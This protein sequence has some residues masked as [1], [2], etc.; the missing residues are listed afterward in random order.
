MRTL[1]EDFRY[2]WRLLAKTPGLTAVVVLTLALGIG[3]NA[4]IFSLVNGFLLRP[5]PV[6]HPEEI[7]VLG[8]TVKGDSPFLFTFSYPAFQ[9]YRNQAASSADVFGFMPTLLGLSADG[10][11]DQVLSSYVT[12]NYFSALGI[13]P[14]L[15]RL[16]MPSEE[17]QP[18]RQP[19]LILGYAYWQKRFGGSPNVIGKQVRV[20]GHSATIVG[21]V[22]KQFQG[23]MSL[24]E[25]DLYMPFSNGA[26]LEDAE[27]NPVTDRSARIVRTMARL[28]PGVSFS[29]AQAT[30][31]VITARLAKQYPS[32]DANLT[33]KVYREQ[34]ARPEP[35]ANNIVAVIAGFFLL[36]AA[37]VLLLACMNVANVL[38][39]R[40][41]VRQREIALRA[42]LGARRVRLIRQM[43]TETVVLGL[44]GGVLGLILGEWANP[45]DISKLVS[46]SLPIRMDYSF[47]W[48][49]FAYGFGAAVVT[50]I[51]VGLLPALRASR[52]DLNGILQQGGR[53]D[54]G[55]GRHRIRS[56][57]V[58][59]Q[60]AGSLLLLVIAGLFVR[61]MQHAESMYLGFDPDRL[62]SLTVDP[63][64]IGYDQTRTESFYRQLK[65]RVQA[66]PGV[67]S[68]SMSF[69]LPFS[70]GG[71]EVDAAAVTVEGQPVAPGQQPPQVFF[72]HVGADYFRTMRVPLLQGRA[73]SDQDD[74]KAP[75]VAI[76]NQTM[77]DRFWPHKN[78]LGQRFTL[79]TPAGAAKTAEIVGVAGN[80]KYVFL[81]EDAT[82]FFYV[83]L[84]QNY[85]SMRALL[86]RTSVTPESLLNPLRDAVRRI[87]PDLPVAQLETMKQTLGGGNGLQIFRVGAQMASIIGGI[88]LL[89]AVV[90]LYGIVS[91]TAAQRTREIGIRMAL[92]GTAR[93]VLRLVIQQGLRML[94]GGLAI[95]LVAALAITRVMTRLLVGI[96]PSDPLTY[97]LV[98]LL[99][100]AIALLA[101]WIPA[102]RATRVDP[103]MALR[104]E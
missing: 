57:L 83:P 74:E 4:L 79:K 77:A 34:L 81:A 25:M 94:L 37:L 31:D 55:S 61:S 51:L 75:V 65:A 86:V 53:S 42:A 52:T 87:A 36:L 20:N 70:S 97:V 103:G 5:L 13:K 102:R 22:P 35:L 18:G 80:G 91:F 98:A 14:Y 67:E 45:G 28:K 95:G 23:T 76:V 72:N 33:V 41:T 62:V 43:L 3:A 10:R 68:V 82:P 56:V 16:L 54:A 93:D 64:Q 60:V 85:T 47:D 88:G 63:H 104:Y 19:V 27:T 46:A 100:S 99:L 50:G 92:G 21:V 38:L 49:V 78:P 84:A 58:V 29:Q 2:G 1:L 96:S 48:H 89:L 9:D 101:C 6:P 69:G 90:G 17:N 24:V 66:Q 71:N 44:M 59:G 15:G 11:A 12:G 73:F 30:L 7:A 32:T 39:A 8:A 26:F 40:A